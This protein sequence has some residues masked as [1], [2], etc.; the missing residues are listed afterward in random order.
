MAT[1]RT[2]MTGGWL[3]PI[4]CAVLLVAVSFGILSPGS[5]EAAS[6]LCRDLEARLATLGQ[7]R[8]VAS[9]AARRYEKAI[10]DQRGQ[11][12]KAERQQ[13]RAGC[14]GG[15]FRRDTGNVCQSLDNTLKRMHDNLATLERKHAGLSRSGGDT[16]RE[17]RRLMASIA[18]NDCRDQ[19]VA[20]RRAREDQ[21]GRPLFEQLFGGPVD[22]DKDKSRRRSPLDDDDRVRAVINRDGP[23]QIAPGVT[24]R[25]RT[26][27]VR[28][29]DGYYFPVSFS[30]PASALDRDEAACKA[31]CPGTEVALYLHRVPDQETDQMVSLA[32]APYTELPAAFLYRR[33]DYERPAS[34]GCNPARGFSVIA[35]EA[36]KP[37]KDAPAA[38]EPVLPVPLSRP[39][40]AA[41]PETLANQAGGLDEDMIK[42]LLTPAEPAPE[43]AGSL[44]GDVQDDDDRKVRVVGPVFLPDPEAAID[45]T[46]PARTQAR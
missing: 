29:C 13:R 46:A 15:F 26:L 39:D 37:D 3:G 40:P 28:T 16:R 19:T 30:T 12:A 11:I 31:M 7:T 22:A 17:R 36:E 38:A 6:R 21:R 34:C 44:P 2:S 27:C 24:G 32:G 4:R 43:P 33:P 18:A 14:S 9:P 20:T 10:R 5:V 45:L 1:T 25:F 23:I 35:G 8:I 41:D 42:S